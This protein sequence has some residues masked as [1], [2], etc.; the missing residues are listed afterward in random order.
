MSRADL[1][2]RV[3]ALNEAINPTGSLTAK[4]AKLTDDQR[5]TYDHWRD[6]CERHC[7]AYTDGTAYACLLSG[8]LSPS[9]RRDV[10]ELLFGPDTHLA[11]NM[12]LADASDAYRRVVLKD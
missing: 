9:L 2:K 7:G 11:A 3:A 8:E 10:H 12:T 1:R 5:Q 6:Q 4:L